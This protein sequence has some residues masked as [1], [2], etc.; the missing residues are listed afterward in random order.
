MPDQPLT[1]AEQPDATSYQTQV[2]LEK[3]CSSVGASRALKD[4]WEK[5]AANC[6]ADRLVSG[7]LKQ[8][9]AIYTNSKHSPGR[10]M[11]VWDLMHSDKAVDQVAIESLLFVFGSLTEDTKYNKLALSIGQRA[12]YVLWLTHPKWTGSKHLKGLRLASN[13]NLGMHKIMARLRHSGFR[14][15]CDYRKLTTAERAALGAVFIECIVQST[16]MFEIVLKKAPKRQWREVRPTDLY[17]QFQARWKQALILH[18]HVSMPMVSS[19][20]PWNNGSDGGYLTRETEVSTVGW[21]RWSEV[22]KQALPC[23]LGA[24]N[25]LQS[26]PYRLDHEQIEFSQALWRS[27]HGLGK[28]PSQTRLPVPSDKWY[29]EQ[30][31]GPSAYWEAVWKWKADCRL[32]PARIGFVHG[33]IAYERIQGAPAI[34]FPWFMDRRGRLYSKGGQLNPQSSD[35]HRSAL[36]FQQQ[37]PMKGN[38]GAFAWS[39]GEAYGLQADWDVRKNY[40]LQ[41]AHII[42]QCGNDPLSRLSYIDSAKEPFR[43]VQLCRDWYN[44]ARDPGY[45]TGTIH[46]LDQT[47]S[48]WGH[49]ACL[50]GDGMLAQFT[51][52]TGSKRCDLYGGLGKL[53][54][55]RIKWLCENSDEDERKTKCLA[56]WLEHDTPRS[57]WKSLLMP[58][59]YG[60]SFQ[61]LESAASLY[62]RDEVKDFLSEK[63]LRILDLA[64]ALA[65]VTNDVVKEALP[66]ATDLSRWLAQTA[67][68]QMKLGRRPLWFTPNGLAV[69]S[70]AS[71]GTSDRVDL[72]LG[73]RKVWIQTSEGTPGTFDKRRT[74]RKL[75]PDFIHSQDGAFLQKFVSHWGTYNHPISCV[76]DCFGTTLDRVSMMRKELNDQWARFYSVDHLERHRLMVSKATGAALPAAPKVG[77]LD[78]KEIGENPFLFC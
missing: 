40:L 2:E 34:W 46:W 38:E 78:P 70:F 57:L 77:T 36:Q 12:E 66:N 43:F 4:G 37:A 53:I 45:T 6:L 56:W 69:E 55:S 3:W 21:E 75:V 76:H 47:C 67:A 62:L 33:L 8:V 74:N 64:T 9:R 20:R 18:S 31:L 65:S 52:V 30:G 23:V 22:S 16:R 44:Y 32:N 35:H 58:I 5:G 7:Y 25:L 24:I 72:Q 14:K 42:A 60:Q 63:G 10:Q 17:W 28:L 39:L 50:T 13:N 11:H 19:P 41:M 48:G 54:V 29:R 73:G 1:T 51:N 26:I 71:E 61:S 68:A 49:V 27:G 59:I 15:A